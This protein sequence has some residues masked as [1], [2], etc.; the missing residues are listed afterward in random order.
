M[1]YILDTYAN[2]KRCTQGVSNEHRNMVGDWIV[3]PDE[4]FS[5]PIDC[6]CLLTIHVAVRQ[7]LHPLLRRSPLLDTVRAFMLLLTV[8][9]EQGPAP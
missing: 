7:A 9:K 8:G 3:D 5:W 1:A 2:G 6:G 4:I